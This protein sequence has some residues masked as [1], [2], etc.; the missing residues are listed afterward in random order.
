MYQDIRKI[1]VTILSGYL[2]SGK[3]TLLNHILTQKHGLKIAVIE[4]EVGAIDVDS[5]LV[6]TSSEEIFQIVNDC[7]CCVISVRNDLARI[8]H[9]LL[10]RGERLDAILVESSGLSDP[11][12]VSATF[13]KDPE[14]ARRLS[15]DGIVTLVDAL[16]IERHL[17]DPTLAGQ[18]NQAIDQIAVAD[19]ILINKSDLVSPEDLA[20]IGRKIQ[21]INAGAEIQHSIHAQVRL[22]SILGIH[23]FEPPTLTGHEPIFLGEPT[24]IGD[25]HH[26]HELHHT[27]E[28]DPTLGSVALLYNQP[29]Q[30]DA[31][32]HWLEEL[33]T[34]AGEDIFRMKGIVAVDG[35][36]RRHVLQGVH[37]IL[38]LRPAEPWGNQVPASKFIFIGRHLQRQALQAGLDSCL[39]S[40]THCRPAAKPVP[41]RTA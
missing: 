25:E 11:T 17:N 20:R 10:D 26:E 22:E 30:E 6:M 19:R 5:D 40:H 33:I 4:N 14:L 3:T 37:R 32:Q 31:L 23:G 38:E 9:H 34:K 29:F 41:R 7:L 36:P 13:F 1:P 21:S 35:D 28:H 27:H 16:H 39:A 15:L 8:L 2:G 24:H 18:D 12:P